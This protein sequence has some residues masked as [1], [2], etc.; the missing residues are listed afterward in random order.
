MNEDM[1]EIFKKMNEGSHYKEIN[2]NCTHTLAL[3]I[4]GNLYGHGNNEYGQLGRI[5]N[6]HPINITSN[7]P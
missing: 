1:S 7:F 2:G 5:P 4:I 3:D 6:W